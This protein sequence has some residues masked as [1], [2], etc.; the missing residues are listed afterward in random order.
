MHVVHD[1]RVQLLATMVNNLSVAFIVA[2]L[3]RGSCRMVG[4]S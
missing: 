2:G 3:L 1:A 4:G